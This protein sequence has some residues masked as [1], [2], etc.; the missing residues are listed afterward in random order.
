VTG[1]DRVMTGVEVEWQLDAIDLR[2]VERWFAARAA[3]GPSASGGASAGGTPAH[4]GA[5]RDAGTSA[6]QVDGAA[7]RVPLLASVPG[8]EAIPAP[9]KRLVDSYL[10]TADWRL[11][12]A[13]YVLRTR[14]RAGRLEATLKDL[15]PSANGLRR[16]LEVTEPLPSADIGDLDP[17][18][19]VGRRLRALAGARPLH[20]VLDVRTRRRPYALEVH[21]ARV[22]EVALDDTVI[23]AGQDRHRIRLQRVEIEVLPPWVESL[24]PLV[25][26]LRQDCGLQPAALSKFEAG[27]LAS[28]LVIPRHSDLGPTEISATSSVGDV[29]YAVLRKDAA[30]MLAHEPGTRLGDDPESLHQMRVATRRLRAALALFGDVM[31]ARAAR[32]S[33]ELR[34]LAG[35]L[36]SVRDLDIQL[37]R[38]DGW[39]EHLPGEHRQALDELADLF[40]RHYTTARAELIEALDSR[41][42]ERL[43]TSLTSLVGQRPSLRA[44]PG[45]VAAL[46]ALPNLVNA[47][48]GDAAKAARRARRSGVLA[49]FH[50]LRIRCK[51][52]RYAIEFTGD[53]YSGDVKRYAKTIAGLQD[54][55]GLVQDAEVAATRL[56]D[57]AL[58]D[59]GEALSHA[60]VFAMGMVAEHC[61]AEAAS[62]LGNLPSTKNVING[63]I[64]HK[65]SHQMDERRAEAAELAVLATAARAVANRAAAD[66]AKPGRARTTL[67][68]LAV[69]PRKAV[70]RSGPSAQPAG[71]ASIGKATK[72]T[73][74]TRPE[75]G[76]ASGAARA[77]AARPARPASG[78]AKTA[79]RNG[80]V[81]PEGGAA[82]DTA[83]TAA[84]AGAEAPAKSATP[85]RRRSA[86]G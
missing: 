60:T 31:P 42:Y 45:Y 21:G 38:L 55:L 56:N 71:T 20:Q 10:D 29:A 61:N 51:R 5:R 34:W 36:G 3:G 30:S 57:I 25:E 50:R 23:V 59:E 67:P 14:R 77:G 85:I 8:L 12:R 4:S 79:A 33:E 70:R 53:L 48:H 65:A 84:A 1:T 19:P 41:R 78:A 13:G 28:G 62:R 46:E 66:A 54:A 49:D 63:A 32:V 74:A 68:N 69:P 9:A 27:L 80:T 39:T 83:E 52:L 73:R 26:R 24:A 18:G 15:V 86:P 44:A 35:V 82:S 2:P 6:S 64:W 43:V 76:A 7:A 75:G 81:R 17:D 37:E 16:R 40:A 72:A 58:S 47:R 11:G 22:G